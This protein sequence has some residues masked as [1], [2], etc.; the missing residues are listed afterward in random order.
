MRVQ[1]EFEEYLVEAPDGCG[2]TLSNYICL[3]LPTQSTVSP[4]ILPDARYAVNPTSV[5]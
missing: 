2:K 1:R 5:R 3:R 4:Q